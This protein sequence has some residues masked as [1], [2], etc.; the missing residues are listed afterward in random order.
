[1]VCLWAVFD[2]FDKGG[3]DGED[4]E[5]DVVCCLD[6]RKSVVVWSGM[7]SGGLS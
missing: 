3:V 4:D 2:W 6:S 1:M 7:L 5:G